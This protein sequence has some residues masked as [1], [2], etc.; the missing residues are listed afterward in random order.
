MTSSLADRLRARGAH[1]ISHPQGWDA[2]VEA[3]DHELNKL[4]PRYTV[5]QVKEKFAGLRF[6][7]EPGTDDPVVAQQMKELVDAAEAASFKL[8][9]SCGQP[10]TLRDDGWWATLCDAHAEQRARKRAER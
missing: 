7:Y 6:Y 10:G 4:S 3:L 9:E 8:C 5:Q 1:D 2:L